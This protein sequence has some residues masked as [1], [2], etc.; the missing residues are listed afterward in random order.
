M[1]RPCKICSWSQV[2][3]FNTFVMM[4]KP[5]LREGVVWCAA[6]GLTV[7]PP[8]VSNHISGH[9]DGF[10]KNPQ[11]KSATYTKTEKQIETIDRISDEFGLSFDEMDIEDA[12]AGQQKISAAIVNA[13]ACI[14]LSDL[15]VCAEDGTPFPNDSTK[16]Y[17][18]MFEIFARAVSLDRYVDVNAATATLQ[19][20]FGE[21]KLIEAIKDVQD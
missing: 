7:T 11:P 10:K 14:C 15:R 20:H 17:K 4:S 3:S 12:I 16:G 2:E 6:Q 13:A 21:A 8:S 19:K 1:G 9:I 18:A 5:S